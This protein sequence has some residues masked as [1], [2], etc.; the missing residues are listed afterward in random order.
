MEPWKL[1]K[2]VRRAWG[3]E[4]HPFCS[5]C[6]LSPSQSLIRLSK[7]SLNAWLLPNEVRDLNNYFV[8]GRLLDCKEQKR[9][10]LPCRERKREGGRE[11]EG[12]ERSEDKALLSL[13]HPYKR[14][15]VSCRSRYLL[16]PTLLLLHCFL[17][18]SAAECYFV[19][20][21]FPIMLLSYKSSTLDS[22]W[23]SQLLSTLFVN[24]FYFLQF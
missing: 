6:I 3:Q 15:W 2:T 21:L 17:C 13:V 11:G 8:L 1:M 19:S 5:P 9:F 18:A 23:S 10:W 16:T 4:S 12:R 14:R 24:N 20:L 7:K 22:C